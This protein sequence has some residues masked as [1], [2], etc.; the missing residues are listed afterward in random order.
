MKKSIRAGAI[1]VNI[2]GKIALSHESLWGFP[3]GGVEKGED[4][5]TTAKREVLEEIGLKDFSST[6]DLGK[7]YR[8]PHGI[9]E[10]TPGSYP[11]EIHMFLFRV[12]SIPELVPEDKKVK[13]TGWFTYKDALKK[14]TNDKDKSFLIK[15]KEVIYKY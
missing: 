2:E 9:D 15:Q 13:N 10:N 4:Y 7:Y 11:M 8:Y 3:R 12:T 6:K 5:L 14:L 1:V